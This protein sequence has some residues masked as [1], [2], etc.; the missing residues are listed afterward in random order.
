MIRMESPR[1]LS[2]LKWPSRCV[3]MCMVE[4]VCVCVC[5]IALGRR[6]TCRG[7][8]GGGS[9]RSPRHMSSLQCRYLAVG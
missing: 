9:K 2:L 1:L 4:C 8:A 6:H 5:V 7:R 3:C